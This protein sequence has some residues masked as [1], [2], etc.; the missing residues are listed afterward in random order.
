MAPISKWIRQFSD[1][2]TFPTDPLIIS[3]KTTDVR[4]G[5]PEPTL[6]FV[7]LGSVMNT[8]TGLPK[9]EVAGAPPAAI[10]LPFQQTH[11][12]TARIE[13]GQSFTQESMLS[14]HVPVISTQKAALPIR[15]ESA[16][17]STL[18]SQNALEPTSVT[19]TLPVGLTETI[20]TSEKQ[21]YFT[22]DG[23]HRK[24]YL[25]ARYLRSAQR[26]RRHRR[27][28]AQ[29]QKE[30]ARSEILRLQ[31]EL[32]YGT[33]QRKEPNVKSLLVSDSA[34]DQTLEA[35]SLSSTS[36]DEFGIPLVCWKDIDL[37][38]EVR[39]IDDEEELARIEKLRRKQGGASEWSTFFVQHA[40]ELTSCKMAQSYEKHKAKC[41]RQKRSIRLP[42][43]ENDVHRVLNWVKENENSTTISM[44]GQA[45][46]PQHSASTGFSPFQ[47]LEKEQRSVTLETIAQARDSKKST[48]AHTGLIDT[49]PS[50]LHCSLQT[51]RPTAAGSPNLVKYLHLGETAPT[52]SPEVI[53]LGK[54]NQSH[55]GTLQ[56]TKHG[57][58]QK[59]MTL[60][61]NPFVQYPY[62]LQREQAKSLL[63]STVIENPTAL[64]KMKE[65]QLEKARAQGKS[66]LSIASSIGDVNS[67]VQVQLSY[68]SQQE[69]GPNEDDL[70]LFTFGE[71]FSSDDDISKVTVPISLSLLIMT[72]YIFLGAIVFSITE[73]KDYLKWAYF[74]FI[75]LSTIGFGDIVPG[76]KMDSEDAKEKLVVIT[77]Y[78]AIG[79]S[80]FAMCFKLMQEEVVDKVKWF[81]SKVGIIKAK[82]RKKAEK[83]P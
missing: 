60:L 18:A 55:Q 81:A 38:L 28:V 51:A 74:C 23:H 10:S 33:L 43:R 53:S 70:S 3:N 76:T 49:L 22:F 45:V 65:E 52:E 78:V 61:E 58:D 6:G 54:A 14:N 71:G 26:Q 25:D 80:V 40:Q 24:F 56:S 4:E 68:Y 37:D 83:A 11:K 5:P 59:Y 17:G 19:I 20:H 64:E 34:Q 47:S 27:R 50:Q 42:K 67:D 62:Y 2:F 30:K 16:F 15:L 79:L 44:K 72:T 36:T 82:D 1:E 66:R 41:R 48:S 7:Q 69:N 31:N 32:S 39:S 75:T 63:Q 13:D 57:T 35:L 21:R 46:I 8:T 29:Q 73:D 12:I 9:L 77:L